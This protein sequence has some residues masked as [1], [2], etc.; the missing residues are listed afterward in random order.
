M[1]EPRRVSTKRRNLS[2]AYPKPILL[3]SQVFSVGNFLF[4][5]DEWLHDRRIRFIHPFTHST[6]PFI[7]LTP[8]NVIL[9]RVNPLPR[10]IGPILMTGPK[11]KDVILMLSRLRDGVGSRQPGIDRF[12]MVI[13]Y[14]DNSDSKQRN[15]QV[16]FGYMPSG[17]R[18]TPKVPFRQSLNLHTIILCL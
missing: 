6:I 7:G 5:M 15:E 9:A 16:Q 18:S 12:H 10:L 4:Y 8:Q 14:R 3:T 13:P 11:H 2:S 1:R 17:Q